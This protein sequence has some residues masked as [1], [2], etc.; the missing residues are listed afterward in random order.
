M[1]EEAKNLVFK[2]E[3]KRS[4]S[5]EQVARE[6]AALRTIKRRITELKILRVYHQRK[7]R[8]VSRQARQRIRIAARRDRE[9][10]TR[11]IAELTQ[12]L[13]TARAKRRDIARRVALARVA[14]SRLAKRAIDRNRAEYEQ[15]KAGLETLRRDHEQSLRV[16]R[17]I[18]GNVRLLR[19]S[20]KERRVEA[21][22]AVRANLPP[23]LIEVFD[24]VKSRIKERPGRSRTEAFLEWVEAHPDD[25]WMVKQR[26]ADRELRQ[27][28][29]A[30]RYKGRELIAAAPGV[31]F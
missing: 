28:V 11:R 16:L 24:E 5:R 26:E 15:A 14:V 8:T 1:S 10:L 2:R 7:I 20:R 27:L 19:S 23:D 6:R 13:R 22:D 18:T 30:Q 9:T 17:E 4:L 29:K 31:P 12:Q 25:V 3:L 21:D